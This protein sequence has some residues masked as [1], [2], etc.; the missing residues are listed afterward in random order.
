MADVVMEFDMMREMTKTFGEAGQTLENDLKM[1][2]AIITLVEGGVLTGG[3][4]N[5]LTDFIDQTLVPETDTLQRKMEEMAV[6][7]D[8]ARKFLE[9]GDETAASRFN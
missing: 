8:N 2:K 5:K 1:L 7:V 4:G 6:D 9:E 3:P